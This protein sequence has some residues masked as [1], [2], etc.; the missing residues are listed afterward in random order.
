MWSSI[1]GTDEISHPSGF[2]AVGVAVAIVLWIPAAA[3]ET[4]SALRHEPNHGAVRVEPSRFGQSLVLVGVVVVAGS[5]P[6]TLLFRW[7]VNATPWW[8]AVMVI[9]SI[10]ATRSFGPRILRAMHRYDPLPDELDRELSSIAASSGMSDVRFGRLGPG[11][12]ERGLNA[13]TLGFGSSPLVLCTPDLLGADAE[14]RDFVVAHEVAHLRRHHHRS[15]FVVSAVGSSF[16]L[17]VLWLVS[18]KAPTDRWLD[19][20]DARS[21]PLAVA[22]VGLAGLVTGAF[23]AWVSR[24]HERMADTDALAEVGSPGESLLRVLVQHDHSD[25]APSRLARWFA[26]HPSPAER[27]AQAASR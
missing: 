23:E 13:L 24:A 8:P 18:A 6:L 14:L 17:G 12:G 4:W 9:A 19:L 5:I 2:V 22:L 25:L 26:P 20:T 11:H 21:L 10:V 16:E 3:V 15:A 27:L 1:R 7:L